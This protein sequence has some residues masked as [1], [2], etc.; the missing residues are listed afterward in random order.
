MTAIPIGLEILNSRDPELPLPAYA[1]IQAAGLDVCANL[2]RE[3]RATGLTLVPGARAL[4]PTGFALAIPQGYEVQIRPRSGLAL[5]SGV[6]LLN[7][8][9]TIDCDYRGEIGV[10]L[11]NLGQEPF[12]VEHGMR[13]AQMVPSP[14]VPARLEVVG[15]LAGTERGPGGFGSTGFHGTGSIGS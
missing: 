6:T 2:P 11:V 7:A 13:I 5:H 9:G 8:P 1:S 12:T 15:T 3:I 10:I 14:V 4:V